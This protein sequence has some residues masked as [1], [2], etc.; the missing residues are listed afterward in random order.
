MNGEN[1][2]VFHTSALD[3]WPH[4]LQRPHLTWTLFSAQL[5]LLVA[6]VGMSLVA[7]AVKLF[8]G[9]PSE[10][11]PAAAFA[12]G[13]LGVVLTPAAWWRVA[14]QLERAE[15]ESALADTNAVAEPIKRHGRGVGAKPEL[16][17]S[18]R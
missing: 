11:Q 9:G 6:F 7:I 1:N 12:L 3:S 18:H 10:A 17:V 15:R 13:L 16:L 8:L 2:H 4:E 14:R 5:W